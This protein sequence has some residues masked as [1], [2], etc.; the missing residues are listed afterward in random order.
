M[1]CVRNEILN[2]KDCT[3]F[4]EEIHN[5][6][7]AEKPTQPCSPHTTPNAVSRLTD[8]YMTFHDDAFK[9][10]FYWLYRNALRFT[11]QNE[12]RCVHFFPNVQQPVRF[13][14]AYDGEDG[15]FRY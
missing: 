8:L 13:V 2:G 10:N 9:G 3:L 11:A 15:I 12:I 5:T 4:S 14:D 6:L 1:Q 7:H